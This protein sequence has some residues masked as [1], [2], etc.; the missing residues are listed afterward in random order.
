MNEFS[1]SPN[2]MANVRDLFSSMPL[3]FSVIRSLIDSSVVTDPISW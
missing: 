2:L 1:V 3:A